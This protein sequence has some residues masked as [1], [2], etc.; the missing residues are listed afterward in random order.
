MVETKILKDRNGNVSV[1]SAKN[2]LVLSE[3]DRERCG[4]CGDPHMH[5]CMWPGDNTDVRFSILDDDD[6]DIERY[7]RCENEGSAKELF[8]D[9]CEYISMY[10]GEI[11]STAEI[12]DRSLFPDFT[13]MDGNTCVYEAVRTQARFPLQDAYRIARG[14]TD[15][16]GEYVVLKTFDHKEGAAGFLDGCRADVSV[17]QIRENGRKRS[18]ITVTEYQIWKTV[19]GKDG[20]RKY[21]YTAVPARDDPGKI[22]SKALRK[23]D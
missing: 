13:K 9:L 21:S 11:V 19:F 12:Y 22:L 14:C 23:A 1:R 20:K 8:L 10:D 5:V 17:L 16:K 15:G 7:Y 2:T 3:Y 18:F 6:M 4:I